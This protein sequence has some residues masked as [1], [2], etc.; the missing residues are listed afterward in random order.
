V[1]VPASSTWKKQGTGQI[2]GVTSVHRVCFGLKALRYTKIEKSGAHRPLLS[3]LS[4]G[5]LTCA[6]PC[7]FETAAGNARRLGSYFNASTHQEAFRSKSL[8]A[9]FG[10]QSVDCSSGR[11]ELWL[12]QTKKSLGCLPTRSLASATPIP[13]L[14]FRSRACDVY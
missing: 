8:S 13:P 7:I 2:S 1:R 9:S 11:S 14:F 10:G 6:L 12:N 5:Y 3:A 4:S